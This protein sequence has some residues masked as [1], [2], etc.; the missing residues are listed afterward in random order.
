METE[1][2]SPRKGL[3]ALAVM[4]GSVFVSSCGIVNPDYVLPNICKELEDAP[5][6]LP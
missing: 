2:R 6:I 1:N 4:L 3:S 5:F